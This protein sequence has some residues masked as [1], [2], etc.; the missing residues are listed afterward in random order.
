MNII[1]YNHTFFSGAINLTSWSNSS[2]YLF[3]VT[4]LPGATISAAYAWSYNV[5]IKMNLTSARSSL[6]DTYE[7]IA[8]LDAN[9]TQ[10]VVGN[11]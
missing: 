6:N 5:I 8:G 11:F 9:D 4:S 10:T 3:G 2:H 7:V 1:S